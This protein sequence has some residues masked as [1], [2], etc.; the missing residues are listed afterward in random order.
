MKKMNIGIAEKIKSEVMDGIHLTQRY[1]IEMG[2]THSENSLKLSYK[3]E[4][5]PNIGLNFMNMKLNYEEVSS[6]LTNE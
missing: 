1:T 6:I 5:N 3:V 2:I 4:L